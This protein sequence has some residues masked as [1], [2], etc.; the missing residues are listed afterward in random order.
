M[1]LKKLPL[2][3]FAFCGFF[4]AVNP[5]FAQ[6]W[7]GTSAPG[8]NWA[9]VASSADGTKLVAADRSGEGIFNSTN[10]GATW[11]K[12]SAPYDYWASVACSTNGT[13][14]VAV[15]VSDTSFTNPGSIY[16]STDS[17]TTWTQTSAPSNNWTSVASSADGTKLVAIAV[18][19]THFCP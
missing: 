11:T 3:A 19:C 6:N 4:T 15:A 14:L 13:K 9:S 16:I 1:K 7:I 10:S 8:A 5:V 2:A 17:G 18:A 12:T